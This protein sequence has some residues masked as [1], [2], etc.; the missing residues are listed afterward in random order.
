M[1]PERTLPLVLGYLN[2]GNPVYR[3]HSIVSRSLLLFGDMENKAHCSV[4]VGQSLVQLQLL[5]PLPQC[6]GIRWAKWLRQMAQAPAANSTTEE[7]SCA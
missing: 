1:K 2:Q 6:Q 3:E 7:H 5:D 4:E